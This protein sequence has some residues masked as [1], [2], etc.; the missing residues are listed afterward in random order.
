MLKFLHTADIHLGTKFSGLGEKGEKARENLKL[1]FKR[2]IDLALER[3]VDLLLISG[4]LFDSNLVSKEASEFVLEEFLRLNDIPVC[5]LPGTHDFYDNSSIYKN[6]EEKG[7]PSNIFLFTNKEK[8]YHVFEKLNLAV[9]GIPLGSNRSKEKQLSSLKKL[10]NLSYHIALAHGSYQIP[11]KSAEDDFPISNEEMENSG[12]DYIALGHWHSFLD[13]SSTKTKAFYPGSPEQLRFGQK[14][15]GNVLLVEMEKEKVKV[16]K[17]KV[18]RLEWKELELSL[19]RFKTEKELVQEIEKYQKERS[20]LKLRFAGMNSVENKLDLEKVVRKLKSNFF[21]LTYDDKTILP[22]KEIL[23]KKLPL[24]TVSGQ[25]VKLMKEKIE[26]APPEGKKI[27]E[28]VLN[29]GY[30]LLKGALVDEN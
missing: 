18:N 19:E 6:W 11:G 28:E 21:Y 4:D 23:E 10:E 14:D 9:Y 20:L 29:L 16:E 2:I 25:F 3:K 12:F 27:E 13:V 1:T 22:E 7:V 8:P 17:I 5:I 24:N 26:K 15:C 30:A